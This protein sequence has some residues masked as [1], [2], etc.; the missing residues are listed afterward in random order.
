M[1]NGIDLS[2]IDL[3]GFGVNEP[4]AQPEAEQATHVRANMAQ[5]FKTNPDQYQRVQRAA[6]Q[7]G[8][9]AFAVEP[10][11]ES[12]E[13]KIKLNQIDFT[14]MAKDSPTTGGFLA[15]YQNAVIAQDDIDVMARIEDVV[16]SVPGGL[17][18]GFGNAVEGAGRFVEAGGRMVDRGLEALLPTEANERIR[19]IDAALV[20]YLGGTPATPLR[21]LGAGV[22]ETGV[23]VAGVE[24]GEENIATDIAD[25][26]GQLGGQIL[27]ALASGGAAAPTVVYTGFQGVQQQGERQEASGTE[28]ET[29]LGDAGLILGGVATAA[30]EKIGLDALLNRI[31]PQ[32][33]NDVARRVADIAIAGGIEAAQETIEGAAQDLIEFFTSNSE[34]EFF[35]DAD[36][37]AIAAGGAAAIARALLQAFVPGRMN[38]A[39]SVQDKEADLDAQAV[40]DSQKIDQLNQLAETSKL[41]ERDKEKFH[42]FVQDADGDNNTEVFIDGPQLALYLR[43]KSAQQLEEDTALQLLADRS[44]LSSNLGVDAQVSVADFTTEIAGTEH[45]EALRPYMTMSPET[46]NSFRKEQS[47]IDTA[48][49]LDKLVNQANENV[50]QYVEAQQIFEDVTA[51]L[52]DTGVVNPQNARTMAQIVPAWATSYAER[53]GSTVAEVYQAAGLTITGPQT[54][55]LARLT[56]EELTQGAVYDESD[57]VYPI[58]PR[59]EWY[60][61]ADFAAR[62]AVVVSMD[63]QQYIDSVRPL[64][65]DE[66]TLDNVEDLRNHIEE[67]RQL[68]P[69][70][71]YDGGQEDGRHRALAAID[72]GIESVPVLLF[73]DQIERFKD[74]PRYVDETEALQQRDPVERGDVRGFYSP[75][76]VSIRLTE[77]ADLSTFLHEFAHFMYEQE[78]KVEGPEILGIHGWYKRNNDMVAAEANDYLQMQGSKTRVTAGNVDAFLDA[79][80]VGDTESNKAIRRAV[81]ENFARGFETYLMEGKAPS[82]ELRNA[83]RTFARWLTQIYRSIR[84][85]LDVNLDD[86]MRKVFDRLIATEEQ[87]AAAEAR[88]RFEPLFTDATM[89]GMTEEQFTDYQATQQESVDK[90]TET[91]RDQVIKQITRQTKRWWKE[92]RADVIAEETER[93]QAERV[94]TARTQLKTGDVKLDLAATK[95]LV[96]VERTDKLGRT[97]IRVPEQLRG[98]TISGARGIHPDEAAGMLG[99]N[100]GAEMLTDLIDAPPIKEVAEANADRIMVERHGDILNDGTIEQQADEAVRN[101]QRGKMIL[102]EL[103]ALNRGTNAPSIERATIKALAEERIGKLSY[104]DIHPGRYRKAEIAAAQESARLLAAGDRAG[105]ASAKT[106]QVMNY[107]LS[108]AAADARNDVVKIVDRMARY[109]KKKVREEIIRAEGGYWEQINK[110]LNRFEFRKTATLV[111]VD[112]ANQDINTWMRERI[113]NDGDGLVL[114]PVVLN[115]SYVTHWKNVP[116]V[117]LQGVND[118]VKNIEHV[119]RY[120]NKINRLQEELDFKT[121]VN[122]WVTHIDE[123][124]PT[125][126]TPRRTDVVEGRKWGRW[127]MA[128]MTKIPFMASWLDGG[129]RAGLSHQILVQPFTDAYDAELRLWKQTGSVVLDA[130]ENRSKEDMRRHNTKIFIPEINDTLF[131][132]QVLAVALNTGNESNLRKLLLGEGWAQPDFP[133]QISMSNPQLQGVLRHMTKNDWKLVQLIWDQMDQLYPQLA[134]VHR[135]TTGLT[136]PKVEATPVDTPFGQFRGGYYPIKYDPNR[137]LRA[138]ENEERLNAETES[139]FGNVGIQA[140]VNASS[141]NER[142]GFYDAIRLSL[143]VVPNHF[144]ETIHYITHHDAVRETN[145]LIRNPQVAEIIKAKLGPEEYAQLRP[146]LNDIAKDGRDAPTKTFWDDILGRL[147]FGVTLGSM[148]FKAST[149]IIQISGL[150]N[151]VAEV[152]LSPV[153]QAARTILNSETTIKEAWDF[154]VS[155]SKVMNHR[156]QTFDREVKNALA[157]L[158]GKRGIVAAAQEMSMKH[159]ALIQTYMVDLPSWHAAYIKSMEQYGDEQRAF[160]YAD[161]VVEN[162]QGSGATKDLAGILR[163]QTETGR[164]FTMFMTF[165]SSLWNLERDLV[166]GTRSGRYSITNV[167]AKAGFLFVIPVLFEMLLR[168]ELGGDE[169]EETLQNVLTKTALF[170]VQ[171]VPFIRDVASGVVG[172]Y[173]YNI[174]PLAQILESGTRSIPG[175]V[176]AGLTDEELTKGQAK[177][178]TKF[179]GAAF[180]VPG[181]GQAWATGEHLYDVLAEGEEFTL[182]QLLFGPKKEP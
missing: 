180:G 27:L 155:N 179:I 54:G 107:Y 181:T 71:I 158:E 5:A 108:I 7:S 72:L 56:G 169:E 117:D 163:N 43:E 142:T 32:I 29:A 73:G 135:R 113:E 140:S 109:N 62:G 8:V 103:K 44:Q 156:A 3:G 33:R 176:D 173:G 121:L 102:E 133:E 16:R 79:G 37:E 111:S 46:Q 159:I 171:S 35:Q 116:Y 63:P 131:G 21:S 88:S 77:A 94:Y 39:T 129:D 69:L 96:G 162:V 139:L 104:R 97:S 82:V 143:D 92:Q 95:E 24:P 60:G 127:A 177:G 38:A 42:Q 91:L 55:E 128:Q 123:A 164:M 13:Q 167:A 165:F 83:F 45:F 90:A 115:E 148:G 93:L 26:L 64:T 147:R 18:K 80:A 19:G 119:A 23:A 22:Q 34:V 15:N 168:G 134:D 6:E 57:P 157:R 132:H 178:A 70:A 105:A 58:A 28:G 89:A 76:Q 75:S 84:G 61:D 118:S 151:T 85:D 4:E 1:T 152:G 166:K 67:G 150:S 20:E 144:Q 153:L 106:R 182:Q 175:V 98:M 120:S 110:I 122:K 68:D 66:E 160:A 101:E 78:L 112:Q 145:K 40:V 50:S 47:D 86:Q 2:K 141:T 174:S 9:P 48:N 12:V 124:Q 11:I 52:T 99:Y 126:F 87:I 81:H 146:W 161:W 149:G 10:D 137:S 31:P 49:Y 59:G 136:P 51:Q 36:R 125:R 25:G 74:L 100:S 114:S 53:T 14:T 130:I 170:P 17:I 154:A 41:K 65:R 138:A 172:D 30:T